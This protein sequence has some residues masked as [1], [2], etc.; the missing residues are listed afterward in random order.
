VE[1]EL[2]SR[3]EGAVVDEDADELLH[4]GSGSSMSSASRRRTCS[5]AGEGELRPYPVPYPVAYGP[6]G[7][8]AA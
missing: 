1:V 2:E 4:H 6:A 3:A 7:S 8:G 5:K